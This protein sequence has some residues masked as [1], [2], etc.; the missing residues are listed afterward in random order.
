MVVRLVNVLL[1][2]MVELES[3][4]RG[5]AKDPLSYRGVTSVIAKCWS[6][7]CWIGW[8]WCTWEDNLPHVNHSA[9]RKLVSHAD[10]TFATQEAI[11]RYPNGGCLYDLQKAFNSVEYPALLNNSL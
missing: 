4:K 10:A 9:Y 3:V 5:G 7:F 8:R 2:A 1:N 6:S 11:S